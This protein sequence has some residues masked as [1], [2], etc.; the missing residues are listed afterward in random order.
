MIIPL[1]SATNEEEIL[2]LNHYTNLQ[3]ICEVVNRFEKKDN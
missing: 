2:N 3:P 1:S